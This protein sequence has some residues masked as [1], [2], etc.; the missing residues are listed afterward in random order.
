LSTSLLTSIM[1]N[2]SL[3]VPRCLPSNFFCVRKAAP[4]VRANTEAIAMLRNSTIN[5]RS[6]HPFLDLNKRA[7]CT[8]KIQKSPLLARPPHRPH[9]FSRVNA[10]SP[11]PPSANFGLKNRL[12]LQ[13]SK[14]QSGN[15]AQLPATSRR[16]VT[17]LILPGRSLV[18]RLNQRRFKLGTTNAPRR[19][20]VG[21]CEIE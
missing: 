20:R 1:P 2:S 9:L 8:H 18:L 7:K 12:R 5:S 15:E 11:G 17:F 6:P 3:V 14:N 16:S 21:N 19:H 4:I 10:N 13:S